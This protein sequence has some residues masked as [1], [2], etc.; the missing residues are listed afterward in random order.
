MNFDVWIFFTGKKNCTGKINISENEIPLE[1]KNKN[2]STATRQKAFEL[3]GAHFVVWVQG[4]DYKQTYKSHKQMLVML[5]EKK[6]E[7]SW[8]WKKKKSNERSR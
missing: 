2:I 1:K 4:V 7:I 8:T 6:L 5:K 3:T